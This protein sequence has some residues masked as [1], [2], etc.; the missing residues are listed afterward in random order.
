MS[1]L[2]TIENAM[3]ITSRKNENGNTYKF[4]SGICLKK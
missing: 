1:S 2:T 3:E 4:N